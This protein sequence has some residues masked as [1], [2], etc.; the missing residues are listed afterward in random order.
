MSP[1]GFESSSKE[2]NPKSTPDPEGWMNLWANPFWKGILVGVCN[3]G[4]TVEKLQTFS[5]L[6]K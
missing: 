3:S 1:E 5:S 2:K 6:A 4:Y